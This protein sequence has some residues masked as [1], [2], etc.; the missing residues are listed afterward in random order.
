M[1]VLLILLHYPSMNS[2]YQLY[3]VMNRK[4]A[5]IQ[6]YIRFLYFYVNGSM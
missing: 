4:T 1:F 6:T 5:E 3:N 2:I